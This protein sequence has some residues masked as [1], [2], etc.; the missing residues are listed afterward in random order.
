MLLQFFRLNNGSINGYGVTHGCGLVAVATFAAPWRP[1]CTR[2]LG[3]PG[4]L[5]S[6]SRLARAPQKNSCAAICLVVANSHVS[7]GSSTWRL[8][9]EMLACLYRQG[10]ESCMRFGT[11]H[12]DIRLDDNNMHKRIFFTL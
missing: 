9:E 10:G 5:V 4:V 6:V 11:L 2:A 7:N 12:R 1:V 3:Y 8:A